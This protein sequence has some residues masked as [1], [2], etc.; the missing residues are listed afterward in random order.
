MTVAAGDCKS[1][2]AHRSRRHLIIDGRLL[3]IR[4]RHADDAA[5]VNYSGPSANIT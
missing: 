1:I 3:I 4:G 5:S 2:R